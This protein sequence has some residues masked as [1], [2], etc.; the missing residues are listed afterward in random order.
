[1]CCACRRDRASSPR[2]HCTPHANPADDRSASDVASRTHRT[3]WELWEH[4]SL[5]LDIPL[6]LAG[7]PSLTYNLWGCRHQDDCTSTLSTYF[8]ITY[9]WILCMALCSRHATATYTRLHE[10]R[11]GRARGYVTRADQYVQAPVSQSQESTCRHTRAHSK[12]GHAHDR[13]HIACMEHKWASRHVARVRDGTALGISAEDALHQALNS[14]R[15][16]C[17]AQPLL[18]SSFIWS[19]ASPV[20]RLRDCKVS[21]CTASVANVSSWVRQ[22]FVTGLG[23][24]SAG[25]YA[26][27]RAERTPS[28]TASVG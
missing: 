14:K 2:A 3:A 15:R 11:R 25:E 7:A 24:G 20:Q 13:M 9:M 26:P 23:V 10:T 4:D 17:S 1:M 27:C 6:G 12:L 28:S 8:S 5:D 16:Q 21:S 18:M 22:G 19:G